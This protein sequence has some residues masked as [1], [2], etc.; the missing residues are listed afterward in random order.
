MPDY[1]LVIVGAGPGG[2]VAA[3]RAAQL[4]LNTAVVERD[5]VGGIC[6]NWGCIP[7]KALLR[8]AEVV[9]LFKHAADYGV[10]YDNLRV[11][12]GKAID[13]SRGVVQRLTRGVES[14][15][16]KNKVTLVK[17]T[18]LL[19]GDGQVEVKGGGTLGA[20]SIIIATG[21]RFRG[22]PSLAVDGK[23]IITSREALELK[24]LPS[25]VVIV[26]GGATGCEFAYLYAAYGV[27][28]T[29]VELLPRLLPTADAEVSQ[30][31]EQSFTQQGITVMTGTKVTKSTAG[32]PV[33]LSLEGPKGAQEL[34]SDL[35]LV[36]VG[37]Q[38]NTDGIGLESAGVAAERGFI[39]VDDA[40][41]TS[42]KNVYAIGDVAGKLALA[43]V[44][45]A[46]GVAVAERLAGKEVPALDYSLMPRAVYCQP[47]V[48]SWGLTEEEAKQTGRPFKVGKFPMLAS[49]KALA[50]GDRQGFAKVLVDEQYGEIIGAHL[51]GAEVT[52]LLA[53]LSMAKMLE[54]TAREVGWLTHA[55]PTLSE[56]VKEAA[57]AA[58]GEAIH[59]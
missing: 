26:G 47:Q 53:E 21:A 4:G 59:I 58:F 23:S 44:A 39:T 41:R 28:V 45:S 6:L 43:H 19:K 40:M 20:K 31:L 7:S 56:A 32:Q 16:R 18:A 34:T 12:F 2:Y 5:Q 46:Q 25:S 30:A 1:D 49:G 52:E 51:I 35:V 8:N 3:I 33:R 11:D 22:L 50:L 37:I 48:A 24:Q 14:L 38:G 55:H 13:R 42:A 17:G 27:K 9:S 29:V 10:T 57:L 36:C 54:G 15:L